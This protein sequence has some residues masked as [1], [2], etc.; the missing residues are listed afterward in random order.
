[1]SLTALYREP[2]LL[3]RNQHRGKRIRRLEHFG[4][5]AKMNAGFLAATEFPEAAKE[6]VIGFI[7]MAEKDEQGRPEVGPIALFGLR[8][9]ENLFVGADGRWDARYVPAFVRRYP[10]AYSRSE[11]SEQYNVVVDAGWEGFNDSDGELLVDADGKAT[12]FL[13]GMIKFMDAFEQEVQ[14]TRILCR[15]IVDL[16]LLKPV[17][18]DVTLPGGQKL[19]A[20]GVRVVDEDK[21]KALPEATSAE[22]LRTGMLGLLYAHLLSTSNVQRLTERLAAR[23]PQ[24]AA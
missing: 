11:G 5:A 16:D 10:L 15:R 24:A 1:M 2:V 23:L 19:N 8:Q 14:R 21:L 7:T 17:Q 6:F 9:E 3:D 12:P 18:I 13:D 4:I 20:G 22:L